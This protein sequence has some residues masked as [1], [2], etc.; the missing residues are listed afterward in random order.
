[1]NSQGRLIGE[2]DLELEPVPGSDLTL[3]VDLDMQRELADAYADDAGAAVFLD[4]RTGEVLAIDSRPG[5]DPNQ[6]TTHFTRER[7]EAL[8]GDRQHPLQN[9]A[10]QSKYAPGS[11]FKVVIALAA[12]EEKVITPKTTI[13]CP[14]YTVLYRSRFSCHKR[15]GHGTVNLHKALVHSC[16]VYFYQVGKEVGIERIARY[17]RLLGFGTPTGIDLPHEEAGLVPDPEWKRRAT[18]ERWFPGET[19][20]VAIGQ[21]ALLVTPVQMA[22]MM[23][24]LATGRVPPAPRV[25]FQE[26]PAPG[27]AEL[28]PIPFQPEHLRSVRAAL[29]DVVNAGGTGWRAR[30]AMRE[31]CGKTG[32]AQVV[33]R[34]AG[35]DS[36]ELAKEIRD[37]SWFAGW[38]PCAEPEVAFA[39]FV[40]H[41]GHG[42]HSAAPIAKQVLEIYFAKQPQPEGIQLVQKQSAAAP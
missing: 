12:L 2:L 38:A 7:W 4:A 5:Y 37:H 42:G 23:L 11:T 14:G 15:G 30:S 27:A 20:S 31:V 1:V 25:R 34:S 22:H 26:L 21:G 28:E 33:A 29:R 32:T 19:I 24:G 16:N 8:T 36:S 39:V 9:R 10:V 41:G 6:F 13:Y 18:G 35:V 3:S 40:E 17:A